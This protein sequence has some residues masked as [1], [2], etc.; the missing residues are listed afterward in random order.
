MVNVLL[1]YYTTK[2]SII[3]IECRLQFFSLSRWQFDETNYKIT[4]FSIH[5]MKSYPL[6]EIFYYFTKW[7]K[8]VSTMNWSTFHKIEIF[9]Q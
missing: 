5:F 3:C 2:C 1:V 6:H 8:M 4:N 7:K 9:I